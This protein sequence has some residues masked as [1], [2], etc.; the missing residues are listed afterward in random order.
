MFNSKTIISWIIKIGLLIIPVLPLVITRSLFFP[1][2]TG[3]NFIFRIIIEIIFILWLWLILTDSNYRPC[4]SVVFYSFAVLIGTLFLATVFSISPYKSFWSGFERM[5]GFWGFWHYF[6]YFLILT[7]VFKKEDWTRFFLISLGTSVVIS[8]YA[9]FQ[10]LGKLSVHQGSVRLDATMGNATYLAIYL[11]FH[12]FLFTLFSFK[13][14]KNWLKIFCGLLALFELFIIY[15]TATRGAI[16]GLLAGLIIFALINVIWARGLARKASLGLLAVIIILPSLFLVFKSSDFV[17]SSQVLSRFASISFAETTTQSRFI[18]WRMAFEAWQ[19]RPVLGWGPESF[20]YIFSKY[21]DPAL[22][23]QEPWFDRAHNVFLDWLTSSG[24]VGFLA[25]LGLF[26]SAIYVLIK[27]FKTNRIEIE[28]LAV[29]LGLLTAYLIHNLFVFDNFTSYMV[30][31]GLLAYWHVIYT[32]SEKSYPEGQVK[33]LG[34]FL[35]PKV[36]WFLISVTSIAVVFSLYFFN[37]KP[38]LAAQGVIESLKQLTYSRDG[39]RTRDLDRGQQ[40]LKEAIAKNTFGTPEVREQLAQYAERIN[41]DPGTSDEEKKQFLKYALSE[42]QIQAEKFP[43]DMRAKAFLSSLHNDSGDPASAIVAAQS[44]LAVS[45]KRQ[46]FYF[47][48][49]EA[50]FKAGDETSAIRVLK[51]AYELAPDYKDAIHNYAVILIFSGYP[52]EAEALLKKHFGMEVYPEA[53]YINAYAALRDFDKIVI[54]WQ[55]LVEQDPVNLR[56]RLSL[57]SAYIKI[58]QDEK[59]ITEIEKIIELSPAFKEQGVAYIRQIRE[60]RLDR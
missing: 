46:Q 36:R 27:C 59:A 17:Q 60:G 38:I 52:Q 35:P 45:D 29:F 55:K 51:K 39:A 21:Y 16:L 31:F 15:H 3:R 8:F 1:F 14:Q 42:M 57:A 44:G 10:L 13:T 41:Q 48:L 2:I 50:Y 24:L 26:G 23:P 25:Y 37:I 4:S 22:W 19:D 6:L 40:V 32:K 7:C 54:I 49:G 43:Y 56:Y 33:I 47:L 9:L 20:V 30:F 18:I 28:E 5:E 53:K 11:V 58:R 34:G 12:V